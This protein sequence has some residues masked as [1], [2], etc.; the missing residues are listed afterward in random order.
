MSR[1]VLYSVPR[2]EYTHIH[3]TFPYLSLVSSATRMPRRISKLSRE[4][5]YSP[6]SMRK[7]KTIFTPRRVLARSSGRSL[8]KPQHSPSMLPVEIIFHGQLKVR[9]KNTYDVCGESRDSS[10][11]NAKEISRG[12]FAVGEASE[13]AAMWPHRRTFNVLSNPYR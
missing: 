9:S 8:I 12:E 3:P 13:S 10:R 7:I 1:L 11:T 2:H 6:R 4:R 5:Y